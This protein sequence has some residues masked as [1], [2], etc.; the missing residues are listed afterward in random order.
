MRAK[1]REIV[2]RVRLTG[3]RTGLATLEML[4]DLE[5]TCIVQIAAGESVEDFGGHMQVSHV[6]DVRNSSSMTALI[7][8]SFDKAARAPLCAG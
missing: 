5:Q 6:D 1:C 7:G 8:P 3:A 4:Q 2:C